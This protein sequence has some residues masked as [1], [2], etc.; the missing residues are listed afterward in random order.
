MFDHVKVLSL[1]ALGVACGEISDPHLDA[2]RMETALGA[3]A[4]YVVVFRNSDH[5][6]ANAAAAVQSA[7][8]E[9]IAT[10]PK[11]GVAIAAS[12]SPDFAA[13]VAK[14]PEVHSAERAAM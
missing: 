7:G 4:S 5:L 2:G 11:I 3:S 10:L 8:G 1:C 14:R 6:P 12:A 9:I 13:R